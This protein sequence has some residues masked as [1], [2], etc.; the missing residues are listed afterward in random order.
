[1]TETATAPGDSTTA[2]PLADSA[3]AVLV[4]EAVG[5]AGESTDFPAF[6]AWLLDRLAQSP[7]PAPWSVL[8]ADFADPQQF[9][10][11][12]ARAR[13]TRNARAPSFSAAPSSSSS[14]SRSASG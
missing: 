5:K 10:R 1:M 2:M 13:P 9:G 11:S 8:A 6:E 14:R 7:L 12:L 4:D 3:W